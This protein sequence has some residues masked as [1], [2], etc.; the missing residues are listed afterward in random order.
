MNR[1]KDY[2]R[3]AGEEA[4]TSLLEG[5]CGFGAVIVKENRII[6]K[7]H[8][9]EKTAGDPTAHAEINAIKTASAQLGRNLAGCV[10]ISTHE[11]C[12]MCATAIV[13]AGINT[14]AYG[15]SI[16]D[17]M[18]QGRRRIDLSCREIFE[19][20]DAAVTIYENVLRDECAILYNEDVRKEI[21]R[22][23]YMN[24]K[25]LVERGEELSRKRIDWF[26][27]NYDT[28]KKGSGDILSEA[29][30]LFIR[31]LGISPGEAPVVHKSENTLVI[32]SK[33]FCPTLE[34]CKIL[35]LD[36]RFVCR[37]F[38][39]EPT[40]L[41]LKQLNPKLRFTRNYE[42]LRP[43]ADYCEEMIILE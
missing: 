38:S 3:L 5:N 36:T 4:K 35:G 28:S 16:K 25:K 20:A 2:M 27:R 17:A 14:L 13:W 37:V 40:E 34:A 9:T 15:Y 12:P 32:H 29:Y 23:R 18:G 30:E 11:P 22:L 1:I 7:T 24:E 26:K 33:N 10:L 21:K 19:R 8:D 31:K 39:Q 43:Y 42:K 6:A 41:L